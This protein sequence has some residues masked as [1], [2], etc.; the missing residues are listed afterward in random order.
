MTWFK[1][2]RRRETPAAPAIPLLFK[3]TE[4]AFEYACQYL[5][6]WLHEGLAIPAIV[7]D[8][9]RFGA[10][11]QVSVQSDGSQIAA[12]RV[13]SADFGFLVMASTAGPR[14]PRLKIGEFV[15]WRA[16]K[17]VAAVAQHSKDDRFG[18]VGLI[19]GTLRP[20]YRDGGWVG[21]ERFLQ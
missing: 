4:A 18:W 11:S 9:T 7:M 21:G 1:F 13:A 3:D 8:A 5:D 16:G 17:H 12:V 14:G 19:V 15:L 10:A 6:C 20:E 2:R